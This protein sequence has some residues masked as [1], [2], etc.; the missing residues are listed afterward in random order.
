MKVPPFESICP[1]RISGTHKFEVVG[2]RY[3]NIW[4]DEA[5]RKHHNVV[6]KACSARY[7]SVV[8]SEQ[9]KGKVVLKRVLEPYVQK[10]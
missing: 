7:D 2:P 10:L 5:E 3:K 1:I 9:I 4:F 6:C 8:F